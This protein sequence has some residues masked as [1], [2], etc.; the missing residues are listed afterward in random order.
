MST[1]LVFDWGVS[2]LRNHIQFRSR[3]EVGGDKL[4]HDPYKAPSYAVHRMGLANGPRAMDVMAGCGTPFAAKM[5]I[6]Q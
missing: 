1:A 5:R 6:C 2:V 4:D 3:V